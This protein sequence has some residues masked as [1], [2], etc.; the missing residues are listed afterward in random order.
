[1]TNF[2]RT[3]QILSIVSKLET[4]YQRRINHTS[5]RATGSN[6]IFKLA[7]TRDPFI[8]KGSAIEKHADKGQCFTINNVILIFL[9]HRVHFWGQIIWLALPS[10]KM[11]VGSV[12]MVQF[13]VELHQRTA[14]SWSQLFEGRLALNPGLNSTLVSLSCVQKYFLGE[15]SLLYLELSIIDL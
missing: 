9:G 14:N 13:Y 2:H 10:A 15:F 6:Y 1:M 3:V 8:S 12:S 5:H 11:F 7:R 4:R